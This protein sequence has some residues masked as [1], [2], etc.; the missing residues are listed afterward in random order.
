MT[1]E[2]C[3]KK[4]VGHTMSIFNTEIIC[5]TCKGEEK[6]HPDYEKARMAEVKEV[7][8]GNYNFKGIGFPK[9]K[10]EGKENE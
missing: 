9:K 4:T 10:V 6:R 7:K 8:K 5:M 2:R 1:C 3:D